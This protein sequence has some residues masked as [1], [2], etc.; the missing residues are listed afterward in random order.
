MFLLSEKCL[1][2]ILALTWISIVICPT[3]ISLWKICTRIRIHFYEK[4]D[5]RI[6]IHFSQMWSPGSVSWSTS[7]WD[8]SETLQ[9]TIEMY[10]RGARVLALGWRD[11]GPLSHQKL[12]VCLVKSRILLLGEI[13]NTWTIL[14]FPSCQTR[15]YSIGVRFLRV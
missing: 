9:Y 15:L 12:K 11:L 7:K 4:V 10:R 14:H 3:W 5:P 1:F 8:G 13:R 6:R 2:Q